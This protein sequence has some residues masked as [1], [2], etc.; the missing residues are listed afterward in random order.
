[1][2]RSTPGE[3]RDR[4]EP[5]RRDLLALGMTVLCLALLLLLSLLGVEV[6]QPDDTGD[7][8]GI[9]DADWCD[10]GSLVTPGR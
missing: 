5:L 7:C 9:A 1:M 6:L 10:A 8:L 2:G 4:G 3:D